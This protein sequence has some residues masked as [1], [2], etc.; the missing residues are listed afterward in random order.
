M[1]KPIALAALCLACSLSH[2]ESA[3]N[4]AAPPFPATSVFADSFGLNATARAPAARQPA[5]QSPSEHGWLPAADSFGLNNVLISAM[6]DCLAAKTE[7]RP[8]G[9]HRCIQM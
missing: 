4:Q 1:M 3:T 8:A 6:A 5:L 7:A 2:G 9:P